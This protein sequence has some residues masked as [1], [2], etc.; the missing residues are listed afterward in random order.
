M[1]QHTQTN[2]LP[3]AFDPT[4]VLQ[5]IPVYYTHWNWGP[6]SFAIV[7]D[8]KFKLSKVSF[9]LA[10]PELLKRFSLLILI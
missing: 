9:H 7:E 8:R 2:H 4:P 10:K 5:N 3:D 1:V 6:L